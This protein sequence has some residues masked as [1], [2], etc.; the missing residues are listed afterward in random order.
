MLLVRRRRHGTGVAVLKKGR[1]PSRLR[2]RGKEGSLSLSPT[3]VKPVSQTQGLELEPYSE[4]GVSTAAKRTTTSARVSA[5][6]GTLTAIFP[7][8]KIAR[9]R[10]VGYGKRRTGGEGH[11]TIVGTSAAGSGCA[12]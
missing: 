5:G 9:S 3:G 12:T 6:T 1:I 4:R 8:T 11:G 2:G 10:E 7:K